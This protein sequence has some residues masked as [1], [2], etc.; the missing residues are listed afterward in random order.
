MKNFILSL[1][2]ILT[3]SV[4]AAQVYVGDGFIYSKGTNLYAKGK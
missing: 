1:I 3:L 4:G 2:T